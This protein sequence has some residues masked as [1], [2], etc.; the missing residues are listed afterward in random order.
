MPETVLFFKKIELFPKRRW[1]LVLKL[2]NLKKSENLHSSRHQLLY[3]PIYLHLIFPILQFEISNWMFFQVWTEFFACKVQVW[4]IKSAKSKRLLNVGNFSM[5]YGYF[6]VF[7][8][9]SRPYVH[10][11]AKF[12]KPYVYS[13]SQ[14]FQVLRLFPT[15]LLF[16]TLEYDQ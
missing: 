9:Y 2:A 14:I 8:V 4:N 6:Q 7:Y 1:I 10:Y 11:F 13:F 5:G 12:S 3:P 16:Q 15:L